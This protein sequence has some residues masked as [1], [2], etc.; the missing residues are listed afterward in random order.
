[1]V[2]A[3]LLWDEASGEAAMFDT[4]ADASEL[5]NLLD[6]HNLK[7]CFLFATHGHGD[8]IFDAERVVE[9]TGAHFFAHP[10]EEISGAEPLQFGDCFSVGQ[11]SIETRKTTGHSPAGTS[12]FVSGLKTPVVI[13]GDALFC[14]SIGGPKVSY[15][16]SLHDLQNSILTLPMETIV[17]PGHG[18]LTTLA[19]ELENNPF[20]THNY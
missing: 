9:K 13:V 11:L 15:Q 7:L 3:F 16:N 2:N 19:F 5:L 18:P 6:A 10:T 8:H 20:L 1:M 4:G 14:C 17:C 12:F